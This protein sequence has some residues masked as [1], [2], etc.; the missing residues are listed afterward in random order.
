MTRT[1]TAALVAIAVAAATALAGCTGNAGGTAGGSTGGTSGGGQEIT[2]LKAGVFLDVTSW[3]PAVADIGFDGPYMS[4]VYDPLVALDNSG[5]PV[6]ALAT[7]WEW[8]ADRL[9]LTADLRTGVTFEDG[10]KFDAA[11]AV[12]NI[13]HLKKGVRS[14]Q[15]YL[16]VSGATAKD[17]D[18]IEIKLTK[19]DDSLLY[20]MG[21]G[22]SWM[23]SPAAI[24]AGSLA[25]GPVGSG[26]YTFDKANSAPQSQYVF[27]KKADHWDTATYPFPS[28]KLFPITDQTASFNAM[29]SG[30]LN[31]QFAN[32]ANLAKAKENGWNVASKPSSW[33]GVQ[34]A[35]RTGAQVKAL[36]EQ[37][38]R[39]AISYAFDS[40]GILQAVGNGAG[41]ATN[42]LWPVDGGVYDKSMDTKYK[43]DMAK[44]KSLLA[45]AGYADGFSVK[46]PMS[47]I[48]QAWQPAANQTFGE[49]GIK[50]EWVDMAMPDYQKNAPTY[51][52]FLA[53]IAMSGNDMATLS[54]Q[55]TTAQW[56]NP[57]PSVDKFPEVK[58]LVD[59]VEK[60]DEGAAQTELLKKLNTKLV[61]LAWWSV[62]Y[63]ADNT[64]FSVKGI[65]VQPVTG[66]M[67]PTLRF[68]QRG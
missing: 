65:K 9:T 67:F 57:N 12:A 33:V 62:W 15:A 36:G 46:M 8:S 59:E 47:P 28:V 25:N 27:T 21:L 1:R 44:A 30:Q 10:Q 45:E 63:Q 58:A 7:K 49:L 54:D 26:P 5:K 14:G 50:V 22:R 17:E 68:I 60:A 11:A 20:F 55:V 39:Q 2:E 43:T 40:A 4:A 42:Q 19:R 61:D 16:N 32:A 29:L 37:K 3:D 66:M 41:T 52:M 6:P 35:D 53:V 31:M 38:V 24:S 18:T 51:P 34:F 23:A 13:E 64:Y 48:F 56:Y